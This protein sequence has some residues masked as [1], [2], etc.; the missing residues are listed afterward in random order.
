MVF[1]RLVIFFFS[2]GSKIT[3]CNLFSGFSKIRKDNIED[4]LKILHA[5]EIVQGTLVNEDE[6]VVS[7]AV[8][9]DILGLQTY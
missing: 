5:L 7:F 8:L 1:E 4:V 9:D 6:K 3:E 2:L